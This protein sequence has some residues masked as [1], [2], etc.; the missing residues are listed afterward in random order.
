MTG[1]RGRR[2]RVLVAAM[3]AWLMPLAP[4]AAENGPPDQVDEPAPGEGEPLEDPTDPPAPTYLASAQPS[5]TIDLTGLSWRRPDVRRVSAPHRY[6]AAV[7]ASRRGWPH[8]SRRV[9]LA[10]GG[11]IYGA[12]VGSPLAGTVNGPLLLTKRDALPPAVADEIRRLNP[13]LVYIVGGLSTAVASHVRRLG[14]DVVRLQG[15]SNYSTAMA[16][17]REVVGLAGTATVIVASGQRWRPS[18]GVP[19][20]AANRRMPVLLSRRGSGRA[21][22]TKRVEALGARRVLV[23]GNRSVIN[24]H[25]VADLPNVSRMRGSSAAATIARLARHGRRLGMTG[26]PV[27]LNGNHW[28]DAAAWG[29]SA[30][31]RNDAVVLS[32]TGRG[33]SRPV[34]KFLSDFNPR[35]VT[36]VRG[37]RSL[38]RVAGCQI[39]RGRF[40]NWFCAEQ[41]LRRQGYVVPRGHVDG[42]RDRFSVFAIYAF[43]KVA[44]LR[45]NGRFGNREWRLMLRNPR[46][47][48]RRPDLPAKHLE[49]NIGKQLILLIERGRV[50]NHIHT[51]TGKA[52]TPTIRGT[53]TVY[54]KRPYRQANGMYKSIFF[55]GG[56]AIHGYPSIPLYPA[57][58]GC[59][60]TYDGNQ[61]FIYPRVFIGERVATY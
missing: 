13:N 39:R 28:A 55:Y 11:A 40:R 29:T 6:R 9:V 27:I 19:A 34:A 38:P 20:V 37:E 18:L 17:A 30:G 4:A 36:A 54:E 26:R 22:L 57:S 25:V 49:I 2:S 3:V 10:G 58:H 44:G 52:S 21:A 45:P 32:S 60:R 7:T 46:L 1:F 24:S 59:A 15:P 14:A 61:D 43:E 8:G 50:R 47:K 53:F 41:T 51:S 31:D 42:T 23:I 48:V 35:G 5:A 16:V 56:Y 33:L 12:L